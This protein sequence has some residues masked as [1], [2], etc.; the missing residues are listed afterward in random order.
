LSSS[1]ERK[2]PDILQQELE[3]TKGI[4]RL[5]PAF[6][7]RDH[8]RGLKRIGI[9][10]DYIGKRGWLC[11]RWI[12]SCT[13]TSLSNN[14]FRPEDEGLSFINF[15]K[16]DVKLSF[17]EA[18][19]LLPERMLGK[20]YARKHN[21]TFGVLS[22]LLDI[23]S[24][25]AYHIHPREKDARTFWNMNPKEEAYYYLETEKKGSLPYSHLGLHPYIRPKDLLLILK[26]WNDDKILDL[27]P[28]YRLN[29][30]EGFHLFAGIPHAPGTALTLELQEE[31]D[32]SNLLQAVVNNKQMTKER[33]LKGL[34]SEE[35]VLKLIDWEKSK[36]PEFYRK[37][38]TQPE[39]IRGDNEGFC[40]YW[41][42]NPNRTV[43]FSGKEVRIKPGASYE[44]TEKGAYALLAWKGK[45]EIEDIAIIARDHYADELF[46]SFET[47]IIPHTVRNTGNEELVFYKIFG[48]DVNIEPLIYS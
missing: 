37:Y 9:K 1:I 47:A 16:N 30:R 8:Y 38:H 43:K 6:V 39:K 44:V 17:K 35:E 19:H 4:L 3:L 36:D 15:N 5:K 23:G 20:R 42:F 25:I 22:K 40:E 12:A 11:E 14:L 13:E 21:D 28:A 48:A 33:M 32:V 31:S 24:P 27:S 10:K 26:R 29:F 7:A 2:I 45:G 46:I 18:L 41:V 34:K